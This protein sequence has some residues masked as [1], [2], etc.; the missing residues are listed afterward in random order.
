MEPPSPGSLGQNQGVG[1]GSKYHHTT[2]QRSSPLNVNAAV[3]CKTVMTE[4]HNF[5]LAH[6]KEKKKKKKEKHFATFWFSTFCHAIGT[7]VVM[8]L[9]KDE[10]YV[11]HNFIF[12]VLSYIAYPPSIH[13]DSYDELMGDQLGIAIIYW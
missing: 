12:F 5:E 11:S 4:S 9:L 8:K 13:I 7:V 1:Q 2:H 6:L 3:V 10:W